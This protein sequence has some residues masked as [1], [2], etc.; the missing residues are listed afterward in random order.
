MPKWPSDDGTALVMR[1]FI[2]GL[3]PTFGSRIFGEWYKS[4]TPALGAEGAGA[5][6]GFPDHFCYGGII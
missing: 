6:T 2:V 3:S 4:S 1:L 5:T